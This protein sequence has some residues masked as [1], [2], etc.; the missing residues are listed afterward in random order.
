MMRDFCSGL[1]RANTVV[2]GIAADSA[3]SSS[4]A[5]SA[6]LSTRPS[7]S[8]MSRQILAATVP[9]SP[10][11]IFTAMPSPASSAIERAASALAG[12]GR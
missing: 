10:V 3:S 9:L 5:I 2:C 1:T 6:P 4:A 12:S 7:S 11:M 8:P